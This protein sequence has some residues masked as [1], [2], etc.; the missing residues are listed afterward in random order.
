MAEKKIT[1][2]VE[3]LDETMKEEKT[4]LL[5]I[6]NELSEEKTQTSFINV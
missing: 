2:I 5:K 4:A 1:I 3:H 6:Y